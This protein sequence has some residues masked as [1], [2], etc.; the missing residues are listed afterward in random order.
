MTPPERDSWWLRGS[1][2]LP[3]I[4]SSGSIGTAVF[5]WARLGYGWASPPTDG[6]GYWGAPPVWAKAITGPPRR[7]AAI[8]AVCR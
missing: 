1:L 4:P 2:E 7:T 8:T 6:G 5:G 3:L